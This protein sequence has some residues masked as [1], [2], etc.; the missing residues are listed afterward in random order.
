MQVISNLLEPNYTPTLRPEA[1]KVV[2]QELMLS[3]NESLFLKGKITEEMY[4]RAKDL[5]IRVD[6]TLTRKYN[7]P[8]QKDV[9]LER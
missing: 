8:K 5:I 4:I 7:S 6:R 1:I 3:I 9:Q 2:E